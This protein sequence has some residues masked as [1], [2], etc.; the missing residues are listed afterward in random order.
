MEQRI[1]FEKAHARTQPVAGAWLQGLRFHLTASCEGSYR[2]SHVRLPYGVAEPCLTETLQRLLTG[3]SIG[4]VLMVLASTS[5]PCLP[6]E[7]L[8]SYLE[9]LAD[10]LHI[11]LAAPVCASENCGCKSSAIDTV[12]E[13]D[14]CGSSIP[15]LATATLNDA[16]GRSATV[17]A[18]GNAAGDPP[19]SLPT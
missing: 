3:R 8:R 7:E 6:R 13:T 15:A 12:R 16:T 19:S 18:N 2:F 5:A 1:D 14:R 9:S 10:Q 11:P 4:E 17:D